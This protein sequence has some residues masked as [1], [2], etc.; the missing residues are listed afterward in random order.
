MPDL[1]DAWEAMP[2]VRNREARLRAAG[3]SLLDRIC[4]HAR[5]DPEATFRQL[6]A[7]TTAE[8]LRD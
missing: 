8:G 1:Q 2:E 7:V 4:L 3:V 5:R 6:Y